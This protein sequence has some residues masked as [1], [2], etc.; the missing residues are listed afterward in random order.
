M[1]F[2]DAAVKFDVSQGEFIIESAAERFL[3]FEFFS[4]TCGW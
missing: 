3:W 1:K 2:E 4:V